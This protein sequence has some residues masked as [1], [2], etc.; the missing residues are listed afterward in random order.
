MYEK[1]PEVLGRKV[2]YVVACPI[3]PGPAPPVLFF[4]SSTAP[5]VAI[6]CLTASATTAHSSRS[7]LRRKLEFRN[8]TTG[9]ISSTT[10][11]PRR[12][13][14]SGDQWL[15]IFLMATR[16][17]GRTSGVFLKSQKDTRGLNAASSARRDRRRWEA[18]ARP[19]VAR[20]A[21]PAAL[22]PSSRP[23]ARSSCQGRSSGY[24]RDLSRCPWAGRS[25]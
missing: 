1:T 19:G 25:S 2:D 13:A 10:W 18:E 14:T 7:S 23:G 6:G 20:R 15:G 12:Y 22:H 3:V 17:G 16:T 9:W 21:P 24:P 4:T 8:L 5:F 11:R